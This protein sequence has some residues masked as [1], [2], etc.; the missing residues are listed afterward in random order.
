MR[1]AAQKVEQLILRFINK[2]VTTK[3]KQELTRLVAGRVG[4]ITVDSEFL[5]LITKIVGKDVMDIFKQDYQSDYID[6]QRELEMKKRT[7]RKKIASKVL[8]KVPVSLST[9][10]KEQNGIDIKEKVSKSEFSDKV[11]W[12]T[13]KIRAMQS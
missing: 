13:D 9:V 12:I 6:L 11:S 10:F 3:C 7:R 4:G 2:P 5:K 8:L 1:E